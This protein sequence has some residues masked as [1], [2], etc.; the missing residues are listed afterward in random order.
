MINIITRFYQKKKARPG[1]F[2]FTPWWLSGKQSICNAGDLDL[3]DPLEEGMAAHSSV[4][5]CRIPWTEE[6]GGPQS[7]GPQ[8]QTPLKRLSSSSSSSSIYI[9]T[10]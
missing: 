2:N 7:M 9:L 8:S 3:I 6:P 5:A 10:T 4:L 1:F